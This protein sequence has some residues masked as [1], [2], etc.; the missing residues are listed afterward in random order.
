MTQ[1]K[2]KKEFP[3]H[4][5]VSSNLYV[6]LIMKSKDIRYTQEERLEMANFIDMHQWWTSKNDIEAWIV[7]KE[8]W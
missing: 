3:Y 8:H 4:Q 6:Q 2:Y 1:Y 7:S 5:I